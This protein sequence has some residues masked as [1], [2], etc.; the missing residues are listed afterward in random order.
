MN[1]GIAFFRFVMGLHLW[2]IHT[3]ACQIIYVDAA[4]SNMSRVDGVA[5]A[6]SLVSNQYTD[7]NWSLR[8]STSLANNNT[9]YEAGGGEIVPV[10]RQT[11]TGI[12]PGLYDVY[13]YFWIATNVNWQISASLGNISYATHSGTNTTQGAPIAFTPASA[14]HLRVPSADLVNGTFATGSAPTLAVAGTD[15]TLARHYLGKHW[16]GATGNLVIFIK[17]GSLIGNAANSRTFYDGLGY[18]PAAGSSPIIGSSWAAG[19]GAPV[20]SS[21][22]IGS[23][24]WGDGT[25]NNADNTA[26]HAT[27]DGDPSTAHIEPMELADG[28]SVRLSGKVNFQ[29]SITN[30]TGTVQYRWGL[31]HHNG[32]TNAAAWTGYWAGNGTTGNPGALFRQN[33]TS[34]LYVSSNTANG[35]YLSASPNAPGTAN[36][37]AGNY[38]FNFVITRM[39]TGVQLSARLTRAADGAILTDIVATDSSAYTAFTRIGFLSGNSLDAD[40]ISLFDLNLEYPYVAPLPPEPGDIVQVA[41]NGTWTWF[42]DE[43]AIWHKG[44]LYSGYM[45]SDGNPGVTRY[46]PINHTATHANLGTATSLQV[47]DHNNPSLTILPDG[48]LLAVYSKHGSAS[49]F[50]YRTS[51]NDSPASLA[52]WG[53]ENIKATP[54]GN[55]YANTFRLTGN[56]AGE[57]NTIYNFSRCINY[58]PCLT[59][60]SNNGASWGDVTQVINVGTGGTRPYPRYVSDRVGRIDMIYTD[61]HPR[62]ENNSIYHLFYQNQSFRKTDGTLIKMLANLPIQHGIVSDPNSGEKGAVVYQYNAA[63]GRGWTWDV[64]YGVGGHPICA[65]QTQR[66][67]VTG[68]G[69]NHDRIYYHYARWT[70]TSWQSTFIAHGGRGL[71]SAEDDYGGGMALDPEDPRVVYVSSNAA[72]PFSLDNLNNVPLATNERYEIYRG[73]TLDGGLTF[74]WTPITQNSV[75]DNLRP[76]VPENHGLARHLLWMQGTYTSY[77]SY[78]TKVMG[79]FDEP[80][81]DLNSWRTANNLAASPGLDSDSDGLA[82]FIE[83]ALGGDPNNAADC[84]MPKLEGSDFSFH[85][86]PLRTDLECVVETSNNLTDWLPVAIIRAGGLGHTISP[87]LTLRQVNG[88]P[89]TLQLS[90]LPA[91]QG[92]RSFV[93]LKVQLAPKP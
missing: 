69:W 27:I 80:V 28:Q 41:P 1:R 55:T 67:D 73:I 74:R 65:Y 23:I 21:P 31:F 15:R 12:A 9:V 26:V 57:N 52:D 56:N 92:A 50:Y 16:V 14:N 53:A 13:A 42:N 71:Y 8:T 62:N 54:A 60:S 32:S 20:L 11:V 22:T 75:D 58:N 91:R 45:L 25:N 61:G 3:A 68:S 84:P 35:N 59:L 29:S 24:I 89:V 51:T 78:N 34:S 17:N 70:G 4:A 44:A 90:P 66:D 82:D 39:G 86:L 48:K 93:R 63:W 79:I 30:T 87:G 46:D 81:E 37:A 33:G 85:Y 19:L 43:R 18:A 2:M 64:H 7:N 36:I 38:D 83:Y 47:D 76:I 5:F 40:Q 10:I 6:P 77:T 88:N 49:Q 72:N